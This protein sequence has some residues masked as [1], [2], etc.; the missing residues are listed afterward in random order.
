MTLAYEKYEENGDL[1]VKSFLID[2]SLNENDWKVTRDSIPKY[3][4]SFKGMPLVLYEKAQDVFDHPIEG[5]S[6]AEIIQNQARFAIGRIEKVIKSGSKY[7][8]ISKI[9]NPAAKEAIKNHDIPFFVSPTVVHDASEQNTF[10]KWAGLQ[11][12]IV[13][14]PAYGA[15][16]AQITGLCEGDGQKCMNALASASQED[17]GFCVKTTLLNLVSKQ[18]GDS[19]HSSL[20]QAAVSEIP[21]MSA[22]TQALDT[23][24]FVSIEDYNALKAQVDTFK[25]AAEEAKTTYQKQIDGI[26]EERRVEKIKT[27]VSTKIADSTKASETVK[28]FVDAKATPELVAE[29]MALIPEPQ[30]TETNAGKFTNPQTSSASASNGKWFDSFQRYMREVIPQ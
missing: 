20:A 1:L 6:L 2:D 4:E 10:T 13:S 11:L 17:C 7:F 16:K 22:Q 23:S 14:K 28:K 12:A 9:T 26:N 15:S 29:A 24:K 5:K 27:L 19:S 18:S 30:K 21:V 8:A 25:V 3:V